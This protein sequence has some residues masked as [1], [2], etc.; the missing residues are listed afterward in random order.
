MWLIWRLVGLAAPAM[1][2]LGRAAL[3]VAAVVV[4]LPTWAP[5]A[6]TLDVAF[7]LATVLVLARY[8]RLDDRRGLVAL[9]VIGLLWAN[10]HG[11][12][13]LALPACVVIALVALPIGVRWG[14]WP[15]RAAA[16]IATAGFAGVAATI[17][18]PYGP[19][20]LVYPFDRAV[21]SAFS[22]AIVEWG[23]PAFGAVELLPFRV[24]LAALLL[25]AIWIPA[26]SRDPLFVLT[27]AA[28][29]FAAL[30]SVR[31]L[32]IAGPLVV[33]ALA[34]AFGAAL[35]RWRGVAVSSEGARGA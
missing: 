23:S 34:P 35:G 22:P 10:L 21:A 33:V 1:A 29:V 31:F 7:V 24:L 9:P 8:L 30:G 25:V 12:A 16:P 2:P 15:R 17:V 26:R 13:I 4:T 27:A 19:W 3:V 18:N 11:S 20:L 5:R 6:Q 28:W 32:S 14:T